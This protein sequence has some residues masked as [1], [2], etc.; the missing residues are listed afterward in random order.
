VP[1]GRDTGQTAEWQF[2]HIIGY[3]DLATLVIA[4]ER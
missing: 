2:R 1:D 3:S 4:I